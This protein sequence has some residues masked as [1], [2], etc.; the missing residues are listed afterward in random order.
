MA[1]PEIAQDVHDVSLVP[2]YRN[3]ATSTEV[4][5]A[6]PFHAFAQGALVAV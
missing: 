2:P 3:R 1:I 4:R 6:Y 5:V